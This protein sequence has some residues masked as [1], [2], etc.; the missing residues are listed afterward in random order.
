VRE[1][2]RVAGKLA[3]VGDTNRAVTALAQAVGGAG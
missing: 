1:A 2:A 3:G